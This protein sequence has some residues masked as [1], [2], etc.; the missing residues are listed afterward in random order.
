MASIFTG[1]RGQFWLSLLITTTTS[2]QQQPTP[3]RI[4]SR[5]PGL[6]PELTGGQTSTTSLK[7]LP[8]EKAFQPWTLQNR[9]DQ[10]ALGTCFLCNFSGEVKAKSGKLNDSYS[11]QP[12]LWISS[13][14]KWLVRRNV[15]KHRSYFQSYTITHTSLS[16]KDTLSVSLYNEIQLLLLKEISKTQTK[17]QWDSTSHLVGRSQSKGIK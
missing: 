15:V 16:A 9:E 1:T 17:P 11:I 6:L 8:S 13:F 5:C 14:K 7:R 4:M 10:E 2:E 12:W 3:G